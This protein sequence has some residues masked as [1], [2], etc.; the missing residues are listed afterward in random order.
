MVSG[1]MGR[2]A[3]GRQQKLIRWISFGFCVFN[4]T[5]ISFIKSSHQHFIFPCILPPFSVSFPLFCF[6]VSSAAVGMLLLSLL[7]YR[8]HFGFT[9]LLL[10]FL[11][12]SF[13]FPFSHIF[14]YCFSVAVQKFS[15]CANFSL[16]VTSNL[17][18]LPACHAPLISPPLT[19]S[20]PLFPLAVKLFTK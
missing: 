11:S 17:R 12:L 8:R 4:H 1:R 3:E 7:L 13:S 5:P 15:L 6:T 16:I 18:R 14:V 19:H 10:S 2:G 9:F 20:L